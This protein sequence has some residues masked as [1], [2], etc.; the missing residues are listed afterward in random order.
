METINANTGSDNIRLGDIEIESSFYGHLG[1]IAEYFNELE[2][3]TF[4]DSLM[5]KK[6]AHK[7]T[8]GDAILA[9]VL[10]G[11]SFQRRQLYLFPQFFE[12]LPVSRLFGK[13]LQLSSG[14]NFTEVKWGNVHSQAQKKGTRSQD[15]LYL[16]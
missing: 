4:F 3:R 1:L 5:P 16:V 14:H 7:V 2:L 11:L 10:N 9:F 15:R 6:R 13:D 8:H 12:N